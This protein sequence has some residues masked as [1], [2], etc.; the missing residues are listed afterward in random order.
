[1]TGFKV[2]IIIFAIQV[3][4]HHRDKACLI[5]PVIGLTHFD[6]GYLGY[7]IRLIGGF[8]D[9]GKEMF[10]LHRLRAFSGINA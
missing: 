7:G 6:T 8:Q 4:R 9:I 10:F 2:K 1:M 5:L 3:C